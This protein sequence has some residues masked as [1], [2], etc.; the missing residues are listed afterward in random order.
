MMNRLIGG[1]PIMLAT[2]LLVVI[3]L[4]ILLSLGPPF[5]FTQIRAGLDGRPFTLMKC[6][7]M[8]DVRYPDEPDDVRITR[9]GAF[10]RKTSLDELPSLVNVMRRDMVLVGPR[11][12]LL[13]YNQHYPARQARRLDVRPGLTGWVQVNGRNSLTWDE[14]LELDVWY[15]E[16]RSPWLDVRILART[17]PVVFSRTS[18]GYD[19]HATMPVFPRE[20]SHDGEGSKRPSEHPQPGTA[21]KCQPK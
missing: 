10:L 13:E 3:A 4:L 11:P 15:V 9:L 6:R 16:H 18:I 14:K 21:H 7:T 5:L 8:R 12:L 1:L 17:L 20:E 19:G 2:P